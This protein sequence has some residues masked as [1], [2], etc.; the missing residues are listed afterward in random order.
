MGVSEMVRNNQIEEKFVVASG[1]G[2]QKLNKTASAVQFRYQEFKITVQK[3]RER[4]LN[5][6]EARKQLC[7]WICQKQG[8]K[9]KSQSKLDK[10][11][12]QKKRRKRR[13]KKKGA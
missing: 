10:M 11:I 5:R 8:I 13:Q 6:Y 7:E 1:R 4:H 12:K 9:T 3:H 2:G